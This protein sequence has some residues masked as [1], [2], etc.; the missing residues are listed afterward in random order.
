[1]KSIYESFGE[2]VRKRRKELNLSQEDLA[3]QTGKDTRSIVAIEGGDRNPTMRTIHSLCK[4]LK[5]SSSKLLP[6]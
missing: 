2:N 1:M 3:Y 5:I 4:V 6:F